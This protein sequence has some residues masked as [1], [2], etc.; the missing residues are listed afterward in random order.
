MIGRKQSNKQH[1]GGQEP[2][3]PL[4]GLSVSSL[5]SHSGELSRMGVAQSLR[6]NTTP[7]CGESTV[8]CQGTASSHS[9]P[10]ASRQ[11]SLLK[12]SPPA[13]VPR[14]RQTMPSVLLF[15][16]RALPSPSKRS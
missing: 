4:I 16:N 8:A 11:A 15:M 12:S 6:A 13:M 3:S 5:A 1:G 10:S 7:Y 9:R 14:A 2:P